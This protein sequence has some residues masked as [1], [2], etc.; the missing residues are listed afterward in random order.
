MSLL[1]LE[2]GPRVYRRKWSLKFTHINEEFKPA[3]IETNKYPHSLE[4]PVRL[5]PHKQLL[6]T[7][8]TL[9]RSLV[10]LVNYEFLIFGGFIS[11]LSLLDD[12]HKSYKSPFSLKKG[13]WNLEEI[14]TQ[15]MI[16]FILSL[17]HFLCLF[18]LNNR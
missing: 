12:L 6:I 14:A 10:K 9:G 2:N 3:G 13:S 1:V 5:V 17:T 18:S 11:L 16:S 4:L 7:L 15:H 8:V